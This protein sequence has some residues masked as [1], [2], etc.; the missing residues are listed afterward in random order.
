M[1][2]VDVP[3]SQP[4]SS[5]RKVA[6][7]VSSL[8]RPDAVAILRTLPPKF[9][10][11][12]A[13]EIKMMDEVT[14]RQREA[15][16]RDLAEALDDGVNRPGGERLARALLADLVSDDQEV[17]ETLKLAVGENTHNFGTIANINGKDLANILCKEQPSTVAIILSFMQPKKAAEIMGCFDDEFRNAIIVRLA[18]KRHADPQII[19]RIKEIFV[20]KV[21]S[22]LHTSKDGESD[23]LGG[24]EFV[25]EMFQHTERSLEEELMAE[26][27][28][29]NEE[30]A[31][32][33][34][35]LMFTFEDICKLSDPDIQRV[36][37]EVPSNTLVVALRGVPEDI[38]DKILGN[39]SKRAAENLREE[40]EMMGRVKLKDVENE[41]RN[42][43]AT[44]R[45]LEAAGEITISQG[46]AEDV[47]V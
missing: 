20:D 22:L 2:S 47:Y 32:H 4:L 1:S 10:R 25:A 15:A 35:D 38:M 45:N 18:E 16:F 37:R 5:L 19:T 41:Q 30:T 34:R 39:L 7:V 44:I 26:I 13:A 36:L 21:I 28:N 40:M 12:V 8:D 9:V 46:A 42:V 31:E 14:P 23:F 6:I 3:V 27:E 43:V 24:P 11:A 33:I 29:L 17:D